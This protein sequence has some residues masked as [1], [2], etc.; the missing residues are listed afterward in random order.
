MANKI[1]LILTL[2]LTTFTACL[3]CNDVR[4]LLDNQETP[5]HEN[6]QFLVEVATLCVC[7]YLI[8]DYDE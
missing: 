7:V 3:L 8:I 6:W 2:T 4:W 1:R 5:E